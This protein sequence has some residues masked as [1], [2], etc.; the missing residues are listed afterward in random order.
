MLS[1]KER[2]PT[3][4]PR[5]PVTTLLIALALTVA[6]W[7]IPF[8]DLI[9]YP[10]RLFVTFIHEGGHALAA[11]LTGAD[12]H[13]LQV[14]P[15]ASGLVYT[16][17]GGRLSGM[18][19]ASAGY[20]GAM[21]YGAA[22]LVLIRR[23]VAARAVLLASALFV[24]G[25]TLAYGLSS[26]FTVVAGTVLAGGLVAAARYAGPRLASFLVGFLAVQCVVSALFDLKALI[27]LSSPFAPEVHTDADNMAHLTGLPELFWALLWTVL[28][29]AILAAAL[30]AYAADRRGPRVHPGVLPVAGHLRQ[31]G[32]RF[33]RPR[34]MVTARNRPG[35]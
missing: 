3:L 2:I 18:F 21:A 16:V 22:L 1:T 31:C 30:R 34:R 23:A 20:L 5:P 33:T 14:A 12:V 19:T 25:L 32:G 10:F 17:G 7:F 11:L 28:A 6:L 26:L 13:G 24:L 35:R 8:G 4:D 27:A 9:V 15:N 29:L